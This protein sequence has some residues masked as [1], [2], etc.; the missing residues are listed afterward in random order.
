[1][2]QN[3]MPSMLPCYVLL[4]LYNRPLLSD[5]IK[6]YNVCMIF[7]SRHESETCY[8]YIGRCWRALG[9][10]KQLR[11]SLILT[12]LGRPVS[13]TLCIK[14]KVIVLLPLS[15]CH[16]LGISFFTSFQC[17]SVIVGHMIQ[18]VISELYWSWQGTVNEC[19]LQW[20]PHDHY[21]KI[22]QSSKDKPGN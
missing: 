17:S 10:L 20:I 16:C 11:R 5:V 9:K 22:R 13:H 2:K 18:A 1:M 19:S 6:W 4:E 8:Y 14:N 21:L 15:G 3:R 7:Q 12:A